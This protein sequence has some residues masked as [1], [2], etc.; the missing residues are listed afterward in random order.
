MAQIFDLINLKSE[1]VSSSNEVIAVGFVNNGEE[2][3]V[4]NSVIA[5]YSDFSTEE[6][7]II[8]AFVNLMRAKVLEGGSD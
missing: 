1:Q 2:Y 4:L 5:P 8:D 6:K 7:E 3:E